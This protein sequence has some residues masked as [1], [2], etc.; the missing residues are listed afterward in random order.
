[1][2]RTY[3]GRS[4]TYQFYSLV[5]P[6]RN[7]NPRSTT[8]EANTLTITLQNRIVLLNKSRSPWEHRITDICILHLQC[9][10]ENIIN[11]YIVYAHHDQDIRT[12][13]VSHCKCKMQ[14]SVI[15]CSHGL[16]DLFNKTILFCSVMVSV[17]ASSVVD[18]G[19]E[20]CVL[21]S[22]LSVVKGTTV[23]QGCS[24]YFSQTFLSSNVIE[25]ISWTERCNKNPT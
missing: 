19:L 17:F 5:W 16:L 9:K 4:N 10:N 6:D 11:Q 22:I 12:A 14:M 13:Y 23:S 8:L 1:M 3:Y 24:F 15:L 7:S 21:M 25:K 18:R 2:L 20:C